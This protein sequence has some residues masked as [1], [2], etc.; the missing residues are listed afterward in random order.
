[1]ATLENELRIQRLLLQA[2]VDTLEAARSILAA[3]RGNEHIVI[4]LG[5]HIAELDRTIEMQQ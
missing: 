1:M 3:S 4:S 2:A 5:R